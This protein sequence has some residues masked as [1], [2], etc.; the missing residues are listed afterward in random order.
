V[1]RAELKR[2][3]AANE[4]SSLTLEQV[5]EGGKAMSREQLLE[6]DVQLLDA[7][8]GGDR[9]FVA[10][11][12][13]QLAARYGDVELNEQAM[14]L[15]RRAVD[16]ARQTGNRTLLA[17]TMCEAAWQEI[18]AP[19]HPRVDGW[20]ADAQKIL[21]SLSAVPVRTAVSC[22]L[23]REG[24]EQDRG[25]WDEAITLLKQAHALQV[26]E[27][28]QSGLYYSTVLKELST[29]YVGQGRYGEAF[30]A[31]SEAGEAF[32]RGGRGGTRGRAMVH[33]NLGT[34]LV[35]QGEPRAAMT[36]FEASRQ[37]ING[38]QSDDELPLPSRCAWAWALRRIGQP[39]RAQHI[40]AGAAEQLLAQQSI[41]LGALALVHDAALKFDAGA[42]AEARTLAT[43][44]VDLMSANPEA[45][46]STLAQAQA[47]LADIEI[48][49]G[50][51]PQAATRLQQFLATKN[52]PARPAVAILQP[53]L[54]R[55]AEA[56]LSMG[57]LDMATKYSRDALALAQSLARGPDTSADVGEMLVLQAQVKIAAHQPSEAV[58]LLQR[59]VTCLANGLGDSAPRTQEVHKMMTELDHVRL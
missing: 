1:A 59:A 44:A 10:D 33:H 43:K 36:E 27:G 40:I 17:M 42:T 13:T 24:R 25:H 6:K 3:E 23:A 53:V 57:Q 4:F 5:G 46:E 54:A 12:L 41:S 30:Q 8:Y 49:S 19:E 56:S 52:Y 51:A 16:V 55:A 20:L 28:T 45:N 29:I 18:L 35:Y 39:Q 21:S 15:T 58:K 48:R 31:E 14:T 11:M 26:A 37:T 9:E 38:T 47:Q 50:E 7:R 34:L 22:L 32:D 2:A